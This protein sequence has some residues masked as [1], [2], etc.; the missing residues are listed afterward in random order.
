MHK[1]SHPPR[2]GQLREALLIV[3]LVS[4]TLLGCATQKQVKEIVASSNAA[5]LAG[6]LGLPQAGAQGTQTA[7][8]EA[9]DRIETFIAAHPD[10]PSITAP[11]RIRQAMLLLSHRQFNLAEAA[12]N[13]AAPGD[14]HSAR[15]QAL[16][17]NQSTLLWWFANSTKETWTEADQR[18]A[19]NA[20]TNL[21]TEQSQ[22][23]NSVEIRDYLAEM[24]AWIGLAAA[25]QTTSPALAKT[26]LEDALN[27]YAQIFT[28]DDLSALKTMNE[29]LPDP[30]ALSPDVRRRLRARA[31]LEEAKK[32]NTT[33][34]LDARPTA[35]TF[36]EMIR[37]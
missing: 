27:V 35:T 11:L 9:S 14:L 6:N 19:A 10:Q 5:I 36:A 16:K 22:L 30:R 33:N 20:L 18:A 4:L 3:L 24:R 28:Q 1:T 7:W 31:V 34:G 29:Q 17:R 37:G 26:R 8:Q 15:D 32:I 2:P 21:A 23:A 25:R 13:A 12:F